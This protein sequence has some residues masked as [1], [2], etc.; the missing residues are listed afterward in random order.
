LPEERG[1]IIT[2]PHRGIPDRYI[3]IARKAK[4]TGIYL[5]DRSSVSAIFDSTVGS[6]QTKPY[7]ILRTDGLGTPIWVEAVASV[8]IAKRRIADLSEKLPGEY[9]IF[10]AAASKIV[11]KIQ[12]KGAIAAIGSST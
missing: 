1:I 6:M 3:G 8:E 7:D 9:V 10:H 2:G 4:D 5:I 11:A 12:S